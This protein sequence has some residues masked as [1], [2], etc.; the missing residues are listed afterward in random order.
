MKRFTSWSLALALVLAACTS[1]SDEVTTTTAPAATTPPTTNTTT[2]AEYEGPPLYVNLMWH[3]HQPYYPKDADGVYTRPWVRVHATKDYHDMAAMIEDYP[4]LEVTFNLT[5]VLLRQ[6]EDL[7]AGAKDIYWTT[8]EIPASELT[9]EQSGFILDRFFD[10]NPQV[11]ARFPR[12][13]ELADWRTQML[14]DSSKGMSSQ[15]LL[16]LQVLFNLA[17]TDPDFLVVEP[18]ASLVAKGREFTEEDKQVVLTEHRRIVSEIVPLHARLWREG[19]IEV[20]TTPFAHPILPLI[21]DT[22][23]AVVGDP[24]GLAP[25]NRFRE[26]A[27]ADQHIQRGLAVAEQLLGDRPAGMWPG[28]G[29]VA[30]LVMGLFG[31]ND[32]AWVATGEDVLAQSLGIGSFERNGAETVERGDLLYRPWSAEPNRPPNVGMFF[33][34][35]RLS[36]LIGFEY[37]GMNGREAASDLIERLARIRDS[38]DM[39]AATDEGQ[40]YVVSIILDG[41]NAWEH[42]PNDGKE[43]LDA[44]YTGLTTTPWIETITPSSYLEQFAEPEIIPEVFPAAW[45]QPNFATWIGE[46]EE[47]RA[48]DYLSEVR[49]DLRSAEQSGSYEEE[50]LASAYEAMLFA[51]G[52]DWF[53]WYGADQDSGDDGYF[54]RAYRELLGQVYDAI[55]IERPLFL[56]VPIIPQGAAVADR[57]PADLISLTIDGSKEDEWSIAGSYGDT[58]PG[59]IDWA[60][61]KENL[62]LFVGTSPGQV[63]SLFLGTPSGSTTQVTDEGEILGFGGTHALRWNGATACVEP[64]GVVGDCVLARSAVVDSGGI[65]FALPLTAL[66]AIEAGDNILAKFARGVTV[67]PVAGPMGFQVPDISNITV[68]LEVEDPTG[69]DHG[70]G[71]YTYPTDPVFISGSYDLTRFQVGTENDDLVFVFEVVAPIQNPWG[72]PRNLSVQTFDVYI[73]KD[74]GAGTGSRSLING[75]NGSLEADNGWEFGLTIEGWF[76]ALYLADEQGG[77]EETTP[78]FD[79]TVFGEK[80]KVVARVPIGLFGDGDPSSWGYAAVVM[81]QEGFPS[82]GVRR[83][84]DVGPTG[85]QWLL[86][87]GADDVNHTRIIDVAWPDSGVQE[88]ALGNY[89]QVAAGS[90]DDLGPDDFGTIPLLIA[91]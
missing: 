24:T 50:A 29:S 75:R 37:S 52:S 87:G 54:D 57:T 38:L 22:D 70:P 82:T 71:S 66:G 90:I 32:V 83:I 47:A 68:F 61:D 51:E 76:P 49:R 56:S 40:P 14:S 41:E 30:E 48:W 19:V 8:T 27:D 28:E 80:G 23:L 36:D 10:V 34:D 44:F 43:F 15:D 33:R 91:N 62:Y 74:P 5:P 12:Y 9:D 2:V 1:T 85:G 77:V 45:F 79:V 60:F 81:S 72:S 65:E 58:V 3:Q 7:D 59:G 21:A 4:G 25:G 11:I 63:F 78:T 64:V 88:Q 89:S 86:G 39:Q 13:Q 16:D 35:N 26:I 55:D 46:K 67:V 17:W 69:D 53:W 20:T 73:D 42:Y 84:R 6:L 18:L 31:K